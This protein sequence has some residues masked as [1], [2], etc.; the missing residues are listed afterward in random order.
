MSKWIR[1]Y[2]YREM[3]WQPPIVDRLPWRIKV[4]LWNW[5]FPDAG[6]DWRTKKP[7]VR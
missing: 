5:I 1:P 6:I 3:L 2:G 4:A 7:R